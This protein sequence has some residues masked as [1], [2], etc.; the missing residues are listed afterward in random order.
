M[1]LRSLTPWRSQP[2]VPATRGGEFDPFVAMR[3]EMDRVFDQ[4][5]G[6]ARPLRGLTGGWQTISP[7]LDIAETEKDIVV[8]AELPGLDEKDFELTLA[9]DLLTLKG[10]KK[11]QEEKK[12]GDNHYVERRFGSF[13]R[14]V[15]LPFSVTDEA[16][17]AKYDKGVLTV[18]IPKPAEAQTSVRR[19]AVKTA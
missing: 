12:N 14:S 18:R 15:R 13:S 7:A 3:Q 16:V 2:E 5:F 6:E 9:G 4:F 17:D 11:V 10:E 1:N 8:T 19:I